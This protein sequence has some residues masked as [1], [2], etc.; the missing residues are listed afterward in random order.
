VPTRITSINP[1]TGVVGLRLVRVDGNIRAVV[2]GQYGELK[3]T[4][5]YLRYLNPRS[6]N[7]REVTDGG[8]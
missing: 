4:Q 1:P 6:M 2:T 3:L 7:W 8:L 5:G